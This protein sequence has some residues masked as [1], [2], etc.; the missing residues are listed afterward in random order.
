MKPVKITNRN[1]MFTEPMGEGYDLNLGLIIGGQRDYVIDTGLGSGSVEPIFEY[2]KCLGDEKPLIVINTHCHWDHVFGNFMFEKNPIVAHTQ[3]R[4]LLD[5][6]WEEF[7]NECSEYMDGRVIKC[8]PNLT[9]E[10]RLYFPDDGL[11]VFFSPGHSPDHISV[12]DE[13]DRVL[14]AG[15]NI[16]DTDDNIVPWIDTDIETFRKTIGLYREYDFDI[17]ISGHNKPQ[18]RDVVARMEDALEDSWKKQKE[19]TE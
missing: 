4:E 15:D 19:V 9:F 8:L 1:I 13:V 5:E 14:Y 12:F 11:S 7:I 18:G 17:C 6:H 3:C 16:G 2:L 10:D